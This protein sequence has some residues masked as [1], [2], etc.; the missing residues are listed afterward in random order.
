MSSLLDKVDILFEER[1]QEKAIPEHVLTAIKK[2]LERND[3]LRVNDPSRISSERAA[4][5]LTTNGYKISDR[6][7]RRLVKIQFG[8]R[9]WRDE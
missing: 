9:S 4:E 7:L 2:I 3:Q 1:R 6:T 8:R 5:F